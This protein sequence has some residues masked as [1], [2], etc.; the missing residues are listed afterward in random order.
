MKSLAAFINGIGVGAILV[1][2]AMIYDA[3]HEAKPIV[4]APPCMEA[5]TR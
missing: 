3:A 1:G 4:K 5:P 2:L